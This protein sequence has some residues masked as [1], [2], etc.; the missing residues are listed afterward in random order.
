V[1]A[2]GGRALLYDGPQAISSA[3]LYTP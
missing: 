1:L 3:E 2:A